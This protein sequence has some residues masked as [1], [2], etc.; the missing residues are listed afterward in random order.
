MK[1]NL[2]TEINEVKSRTE[3]D[4]RYKADFRLEQLETIVTQYLTNNQNANV[5]LV[6]YVPIATVAC[7][8]SFFRS[9]IK[10]LIDSGKPYNENAIQF[11][12]S[13]NIKFDF[14]IILA[15]QSKRV[16]IGEFI[17]HIL[18][19]NNLNDINSNLSTLTN[20]DF[21]DSLKKYK[22]K[23]LFEDVNK[24]SKA[25]RD[26]SSQI[27]SDI[28]RTFELRHIFCHEFSANVKVD[29]SEVLRCLRNCRIFLKHVDDFIWNLL[30]PNAPETQQDMNIK[31]GK[32]FELLDNELS[33]LIKTIKQLRGENQ[34]GFIHPLLFDKSIE[35][36]KKYRDAKAEADS[37]NYTGGTIYPTIYANSRTWTTKE[38]IASLKEEFGYELKEHKNV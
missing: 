22:R 33:E 32:D 17:S 2:L 31:S 26:N 25:F 16:T 28:K 12:Q 38:K 6:K 27:I 18:P 34:L 29:I 35:E 4:F 7:F 9:V 24:I 19:C 1:R 20:G 5:E 14:D 15:I 23:S 11:N 36:W 21:L 3:R 37:A 13:K 30:H 8:E 10:E